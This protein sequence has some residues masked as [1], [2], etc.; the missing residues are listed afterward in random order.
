MF[1]LS[2][3]PVPAKLTVRFKA[4]QRHGFLGSYGLSVRR[5][6]FG[7]PFTFVQTTGPLGEPSG[8][9]SDSYPHG[10]AISCGELFGTTLTDDP[11]ADPTDYVTAYIAPPAGSN[12]LR[13]DQPFCTFAVSVSG[14]M[15]RTNGTSDGIDGFGPVTYLLGIEQ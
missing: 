11:Q 9:L 7:P 8:K 4:V 5:G 1:H 2:G 15:R 3:E 14:T 10:S 12:W 6:N 13:P